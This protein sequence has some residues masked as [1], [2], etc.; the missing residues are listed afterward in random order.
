MIQYYQVN[1][2]EAPNRSFECATRRAGGGGVR[3][4]GVAGRIA[5]AGAGASPSPRR[6]WLRFTPCLVRH[7]RGRA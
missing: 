1:I 2:R 4:A 6:R 3:H 7:N 5:G